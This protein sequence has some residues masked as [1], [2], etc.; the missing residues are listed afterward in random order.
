MCDWEKSLTFSNI[1]KPGSIER[2]EKQEKVS[3]QRDKEAFLRKQQMLK[4]NYFVA[5]ENG[6]DKCK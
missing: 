2:L 3:V 5:Q 6:N 4:K 1:Y